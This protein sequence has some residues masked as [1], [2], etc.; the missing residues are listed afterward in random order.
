MDAGLEGQTHCFPFLSIAGC[1]MWASTG[2]AGDDTERDGTVSTV[3]WLLMS[4]PDRIDGRRSIEKET[5][6]VQ[7]AATCQ[8]CQAGLSCLVDG[9]TASRT[10][11]GGHFWRTEKGDFLPFP[12]LHVPLSCRCPA[13][14]ALS[15]LFGFRF[16]AGR[17]R[18]VGC[19]VVVVVWLC[20]CTVPS[21]QAQ[22]YTT[23]PCNL[24]MR[25]L[26]LLLLLCGRLLV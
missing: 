9:Q 17:C 26:L 21:P 12:S 1:A 18:G 19:R 11:G 20:G 14:P 16:G 8:A 4:M 22:G 15:W 23:L 6:S 2:Q 24:R 10:E 25:M 13:L 5:R 7:L 3:S